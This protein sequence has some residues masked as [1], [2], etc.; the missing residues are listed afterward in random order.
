MRRLR[1]LNPRRNALGQAMSNEDVSKT[2]KDSRLEMFQQM[3]RSTELDNQE[4]DFDP[5]EDE[6][7][8][9]TALMEF[10][11]SGTNSFDL[12]WNIGADKKIRRSVYTGD[13]LSTMDA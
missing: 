2:L 5:F 1:N 10:E 8:L 13:S 6:V 4:G 12:R 7:W 3:I 9:E 11:G